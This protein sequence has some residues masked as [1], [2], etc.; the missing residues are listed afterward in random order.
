MESLQDKAYNQ[1]YSQIMNLKLYP[2]QRVSDKEFEKSIGVS[3]TPIREAMLR[4]RR[5]NML[6]SMPQSGT[7][8]TRINL[9]KALDVRFVRQT[10]EKAV[11]SADG[12]TITQQQI[13]ELSINLNLQKHAVQAHDIPKL[14]ALDNDFHQKLYQFADSENVWQWLQT[15]STDLNRYRLLR[16]YD[17]NL[18]RTTLI[19]EH[20]GILDALTGHKPLQAESL[21]HN[22]LNLMISEQKSVIDKFPDYFTNID[23]LDDQQ[24]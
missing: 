5:D 12:E 7:Y 16:V 22:H 13:A 11:V 4:L 18:P 10:L 24:A 2:G 6:Y 1:I 21:I 3:R 19:Q 9:K 17:S 23:H 20:Q 14:F 8:V 15:F